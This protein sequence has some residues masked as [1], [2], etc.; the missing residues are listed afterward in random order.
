MERIKTMSKIITNEQ[1][2][3]RLVDHIVENW[4]EREEEKSNEEI[5]DLID[6]IL[7]LKSNYCL[8]CLIATLIDV[9]NLEDDFNDTMDEKNIVVEE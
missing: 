7:Y 2:Y 6:A 8:K 5:R 3:D 4:N 1:Y 9:D